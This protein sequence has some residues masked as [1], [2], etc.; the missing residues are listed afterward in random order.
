M[1]SAQMQFRFALFM[2]SCLD[3]GS[4]ACHLSAR[5]LSVS[6]F[7]S[8][9]CDLGKIV[10]RSQVLG[11][12]HVRGWSFA[13]ARAPKTCSFPDVRIKKRRNNDIKHCAKGHNKYTRS[14]MNKSTW[15]LCLSHVACVSFGQLIAFNCFGSFVP[16]SSPYAQPK[17]YESNGLMGASASDQNLLSPFW[18]MISGPVLHAL[19][20]TGSGNLY[21]FLNFGLTFLSY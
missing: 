14:K 16:I 20:R 8:I 2:C 18:G 4:S 17:T 10:S 15:R 5:D 21:L 9:D 1:C 19:P 6:G 3:V 7:A 13:D 12:Q 11:P